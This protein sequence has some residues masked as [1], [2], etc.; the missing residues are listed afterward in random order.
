MK[1]LVVMVIVF[2]FAIGATACSSQSKNDVETPNVSNSEIKS[3]KEQLVGEWVLKTR[4]DVGG[5]SFDV[6]NYY[7]FEKEGI[8]KVYTVEREM[9]ASF[10]TAVE[11]GLGVQ[12]EGLNNA[13]EARVDF[14]K[15][16]GFDTFSAWVDSQVETF[17]NE[18]KKDEAFPLI[19]EKGYWEVSGNQLTSWQ[20]GDKE[21]EMVT[22]SI[23][24]DILTMT[25]SDMQATVLTKR[26]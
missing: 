4:S 25:T 22:F 11:K 21:K 23:K 15:R 24:G 26:K 17:W 16:E 1:K 14:A 8:F 2:V 20:D 7:V 6:N 18:A 9:K 5:N 10:A 13:D 12:F 3:D 19:N